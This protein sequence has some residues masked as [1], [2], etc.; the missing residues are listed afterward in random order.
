MWYSQTELA[1]D[2]L[3]SKYG[4]FKEIDYLET[5]VLNDEFMVIDKL[6][7]GTFG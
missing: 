3:K 2:K 5:T 1:M 4:E 6:D 7:E